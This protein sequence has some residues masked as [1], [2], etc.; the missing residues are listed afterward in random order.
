MTVPSSVLLLWFPRGCIKL[1]LRVLYT[2]QVTKSTT[3]CNYHIIPP[4][5]VLAFYI[6]LQFLCS[7]SFEDLMQ[8]RVRFST[9]SIVNNRLRHFFN[10]SGA[11]VMPSP[12]IWY[13]RTVT[14]RLLY[15]LGVNFVLNFGSG[16]R[17]FS[18]AS[19]SFA[20]NCGGQP[21]FLI[22]AVVF[23]PGMIYFA[24]VATLLNVV[25]CITSEPISKN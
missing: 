11:G 13:G 9:P 14:V 25:L 6:L 7:A 23:P 5:K 8:F 16:S 1:L 22:H 19:C 21:S 17:M 12:K 3:Q 15:R 18:Q 4:R 2:Y 10:D 20:M 24:L